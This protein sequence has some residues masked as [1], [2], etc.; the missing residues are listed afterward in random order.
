MEGC[1]GEVTERQM[2]QM[3]EKDETDKDYLRYQL[4]H[5]LNDERFMESSVETYLL[6]F[7]G[8]KE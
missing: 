2:S 1:W 6:T 7:E 5:C 4:E 8:Y 3:S